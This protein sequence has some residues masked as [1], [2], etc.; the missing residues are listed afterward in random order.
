MIEKR[1]YEVT[2]RAGD[3]V[4]GQ[5]NPGAGET[6]RLSPTQAAHPLRVG[7]IAIPVSVS[8]DPTAKAPRKRRRS[9]RGRS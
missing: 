6:V 8:S 9:R 2:S 7:D 4:A 1:D 5:P 3:F